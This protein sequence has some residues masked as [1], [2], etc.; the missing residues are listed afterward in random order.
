LR[1]LA[2]LRL[3]SFPVLI[4]GLVKKVV[5]LVFLLCV[6]TAF[7]QRTWVVPKLHEISWKQTIGGGK[8]K[9]SAAETA[10]LK[11]A[12]GRVIAACVKDPGPE[13]PRTARGLFEHLRVG[14][15]DLG[16]EGQKALLVQGNG[17]CMCGAVGNCS[18]WLLSGGRSPQ[19]L[20]SAVGVE[21]Y[22][23]RK[24]ETGGHF[25]LVLASHDSASEFF[26]QRFRFYLSNYERDG[27]VLLD[28]ADPVGRAYAKPRISPTPCD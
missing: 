11:R 22:E 16:P 3:H 20:L 23:V 12:S 19:V 4:G 26:L 21:M 9:L 2:R 24:S 25:D 1:V 8:V 13:D 7:A 15:V 27:C 6:A 17:V 10:L 28:Y 18:F 14:R 5:W